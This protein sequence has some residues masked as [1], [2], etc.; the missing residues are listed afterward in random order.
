VTGTLASL[1][2]RDEPTSA[3]TDVSF[4][5]IAPPEPSDAPP[6]P[7][8][9]AAPPPDRNEDGLGDAPPTT[10]PHLGW[11]TLAGLFGPGLDRGSWRAGVEASAAVAVAR[12]A[13]GRIGLEYAQTLSRVEGLS[14]R[15][16]S[17]FAGPALVVG[18]EVTAVFGVQGLLQRLDLAAASGVDGSPTDGGR[19]L[20]GVRLDACVTWWVAPDVG[21][22]LEGTGKWL[23]G[24]TDARI[25]GVVVATEPALGY[26]IGA[27]AVYGF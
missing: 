21:L 27:G 22:S 7:A 15:W 17:V 4:E 16:A 13:F 24:T 18:E 9:V 23:G 26:S 6:T 25:R 8:A 1:I 11:V 12:P 19:W 5:P 10:D 3:W 14:A 20:G 2:K